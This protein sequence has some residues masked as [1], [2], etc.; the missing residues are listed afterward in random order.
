M[1]KKL[2]H[3]LIFL[4]LGIIIGH[5][6]SSYFLLDTYSPSIY[7][8]GGLQG[9]SDMSNMHSGYAMIDVDILL[10]VPEVSLEVYKDGK[11]GYN[12]KIVTSNYK[13]TP[14]AVNFKPTQGEGYAHVYVNDVKIA[15]LYNEW[16]HIPGE[17]FDQDT[18]LIE[19]VLNANDHSEWMIDDVHISATATVRD[20]L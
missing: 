5:G 3:N 14:E 6:I 20:S 10:P 11:D 4:I 8:G 19:V 2:P 16:F 17:A 1:N 13:F 7:Y 18:N 9:S 15:R 12:I